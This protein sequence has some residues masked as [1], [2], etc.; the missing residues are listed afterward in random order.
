M[1]NLLDL[2]RLELKNHGNAGSEIEHVTFEE[3]ENEKIRNRA[4]D[5]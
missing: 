1:M 5:S 2:R 3:T 4:G